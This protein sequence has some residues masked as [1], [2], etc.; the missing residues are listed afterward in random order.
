MTPA[1]PPLRLLSF[2]G[3]IRAILNAVNEKKLIFGQLTFQATLRSQ[4]HS[5]FVS[6]I[7][8]EKS[9]GNCAGKREEQSRL[10]T[11]FSSYGLSLTFQVCFLLEDLGQIT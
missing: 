11:R 2:E 3:G 10:A 4:Q 5:H 8:T 1:V 9:Q 7:K 6:G